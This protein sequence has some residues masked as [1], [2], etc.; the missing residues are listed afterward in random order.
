MHKRST[1]TRVM[2][3]AV[4]SIMC[5]AQPEVARGLALHLSHWL[6]LEPAGSPCAGSASSWRADSGC[7]PPAGRHVQTHVHWR[8]CVHVHASVQVRARVDVYVRMRVR[9]RMRARA[10]VRA[11]A[12]ACACV[13]VPMCVC[14][15]CACWVREYSA[16]GW[17]SPYASRRICSP[18]FTSS[19]ASSR[20]CSLRASC[21][22]RL[23]RV[24]AS[25]G[26]LGPSLG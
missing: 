25:A 12:C 17:S 20:V 5:A 26:E 3:A 7:A 1:R 18:R 10:R 4:H 21:T 13:C 2:C 22:E 11:H 23:E 15:A 19:S 8:A 16:S 9:M 14:C 24:D 6:A